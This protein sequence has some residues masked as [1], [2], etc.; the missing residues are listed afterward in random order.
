MSMRVIEGK[1]AGEA[2]RAEFAEADKIDK[3]KKEAE[4]EASKRQNKNFV[5]VYPKGWKRLQGLIRTNPSAAR[6]FAFLAENIDGSCGAVVVSQQVIAKELNVHERTI[7]R[8]TD[9]LEDEGAIVR[10]KIG[11]GVYA[12]ALDPQEVW[13]SWDGKKELAAFVTKTLVLKSD[14]SN[15]QVRRKL[16]VMLGELETESE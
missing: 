2:R 10:I 6:V 12:Y 7:R 4:E 3:A 14:K 1:E 16:K 9:W 15:N 13:R 11:T 8:L 5:Q